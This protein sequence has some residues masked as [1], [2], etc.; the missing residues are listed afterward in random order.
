MD[1][2]FDYTTTDV[3]CAI[4]ITAAICLAG[5]ISGLLKR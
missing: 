1:L 4:G 5:F 3:L 2:G